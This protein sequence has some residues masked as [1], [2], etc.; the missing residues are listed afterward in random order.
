MDHTQFSHQQTK[1]SLT[2]T[3]LSDFTGEDGIAALGNVLAYHVTMGNVMS[4]ALSDGDFV[5]MLNQQQVRV[6]VTPGGVIVNDVS[7]T[8]PDVV[9]SNGVI[10]VIDKVLM[11][12][13]Q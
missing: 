4:S 3:N 8:Q 1:H 5:T 6:G 12:H 11:P 13:R 9:A 7:V 10:H 2:G